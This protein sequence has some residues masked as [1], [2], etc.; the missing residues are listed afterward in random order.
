MLV[1]GSKCVRSQL[2]SG[3]EPLAPEL[4]E[5]PTP[6]HPREQEEEEE[7][8]LQTNVFFSILRHVPAALFA[9]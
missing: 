7:S 9:L 5:V 2:G 4:G 1:S 8:M 3:C 6:Q